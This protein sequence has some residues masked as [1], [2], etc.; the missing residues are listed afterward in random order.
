MPNAQ[1]NENRNSSQLITNF[2]A[3]SSNLQK[4]KNFLE[5]LDKLLEDTLKI[6]QIPRDVS[7]GLTELDTLLQIVY[8]LLT[9]VMVIPPI[10]APA[11]SLRTAVGNLRR[12]VQPIKQ[13]ANDIEEKIKP[14]RERLEKIR[15]Y[16]RK[17][18]RL[19]EVLNMFITAE[20]ALMS[21]S[22]SANTS[23]PNS[24]Y[25]RTQRKNLEAFA[26]GII[27]D[28]IQPMK[29][30][31]DMINAMKAVGEALELITKLCHTLTNILKPMLM[32]I[33]AL[34]D[35]S[36][37]LTALNKA[38]D[39]KIGFKWISVSIRDLLSGDAVGFPFT[40]I[41]KKIA[42]G[43]LGPLLKGLKLDVLLS[44]PGLGQII[45]LMRNVLGSLV[46]IQNI[47][48]VTQP[49]MGSM[50]ERKS[51]ESTINKHDV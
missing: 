32:V 18:Q 45:N 11:Q 34:R 2:D 41:L 6:L 38:L 16:L 12:Q 48:S 20:H 31:V 17:I 8:A 15:S 10:T 47:M 26:M 23:Q 25:K 29:V 28:I 27:K 49:Q 33:D 43:I 39:I 9:G 50:F 30:I 46:N 22:D 7:E 21:Q 35:I 24:R 13:R 36:K 19:I 1:S 5:E 4:L 44:I 40:T 3:T 14:H 51:L 37:P 42:S